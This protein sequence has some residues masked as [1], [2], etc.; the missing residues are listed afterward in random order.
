MKVNQNPKNRRKTE[1]AYVVGIHRGHESQPESQEPTTIRDSLRGKRAGAKF[2][3][4][5]RSLS[6]CASPGSNLA[7]H[8]G[9]NGAHGSRDL[10]NAAN[11][12]LKLL[13]SYRTAT[14]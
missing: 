11:I 9:S 14:K 8:Q 1:L 12:V 4:C 2:Y 5:S 7:S 13:Y 10:H 3:N 6:N